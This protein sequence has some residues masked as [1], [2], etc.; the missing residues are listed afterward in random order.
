M[1]I[2]S[3]Y[4]REYHSNCCYELLHFSSAANDFPY[5]Q[6]VYF[7]VNS[8]FA[9]SD[10][11]SKSNAAGIKYVYY[12]RVLVGETTAGSRGLRMAPVKPGSTDRFDSVTDNP[13]SPQIFVIFSKEKAYL[14]YLIE[15]K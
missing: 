3:I 11:C 9:T 12:A 6:G 8:S 5:G 14:E 2:S 15:F 13:Q 7:G 4:L 1:R 10:T